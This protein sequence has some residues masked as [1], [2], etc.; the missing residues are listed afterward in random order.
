MDF[1]QLRDEHKIS[2][3]KDLKLFVNAYSGFDFDRALS[4][5]DQ[6]IFS[7]S[8]SSRIKLAVAGPESAVDGPLQTEAS[9][10][11]LKVLKVAD[12]SEQ[13]LLSPFGEEVILLLPSHGYVRDL[14]LFI[15]ECHRFLG[16]RDRFSDGN[17]IFHLEKLNFQSFISLSG[18][19]TR[20]NLIAQ[21]D[22]LEDCMKSLNKTFVVNILPNACPVSFT[23]CNH[24]ISVCAGSQPAFLF[25]HIGPGI[26][27]CT[28]I[29][30][31]LFSVE[32]WRFLNQKKTAEEFREFLEVQDFIPGESPE[33]L[34]AEIE[35]VYG[36]SIETFLRDCQSMP[37]AEHLW[38]NFIIDEHA[39]SR[40]LN[41]DS[42]PV[43]WISNSFESR[44][45]RLLF[46]DSLLKKKLKTL[47]RSLEEKLEASFE[48]SPHSSVAGK[49]VRDKREIVGYLL[50]DSREL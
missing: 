22:L 20:A 16:E 11:P 37:A 19:Q 1:N 29:D 6:A 10:A 45:N 25:K 17:R 8:L 43:I 28:F 23:S 42:R 35:R 21:R 24:L 39:L 14:D 48:L 36:S 30:Q 15:H 33:R 31:N 49:F 46:G 44:V 12:G 9:V 41:K 50:D 13:T 7:D 2:R 4:A 27:R 38:L 5:S 3:E 34:C 47:I 18:P 26:E 32:L 40:L